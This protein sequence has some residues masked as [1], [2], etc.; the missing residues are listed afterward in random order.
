MAQCEPVGTFPTDCSP[1]E[2]RDMAGGMREWVADILGERTW[3]EAI[4]EPEPPA[5]TERGASPARLLRSGNWMA[6]AEYCR[7]AAR[8]R[9]FSLTRGTGVSFRVA[10]SLGKG[11]R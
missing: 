5:E 3:A 6:T 1:Y 11:S 7:S 4:A 10:R 9:F 2:V 8:T